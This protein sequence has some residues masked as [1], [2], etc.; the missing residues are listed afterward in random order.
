MNNTSQLKSFRPNPPD[1]A[2]VISWIHVGDLHMRAAGEQNDLDLQA[3][4]D[5]I[6]VTFAES[7]SFVF[8]PG[9]N[10][11]HGDAPA[12][13]VVRAA[14]DKL[15]VPWCAIVGDHDA[16]QKSLDNF[17]GFLAEQTHYAFTVGAV[18]FLALN[19][20]DVPEPSSFAVLPEQLGWLEEQLQDATAKEQTKVLLL[21]CYPSDLKRGGEELTRVISEYGVKLIEMGHTHYNEL[22]HDGRTIYAATRSTG[23]IEE[24]PVGFS[25]TNL[26][27]DVVSW[28]FFA[29]G[30]LPAV[31]ITSPADD[32]LMAD[33]AQL[34]SSRGAAVRVRA[35]IWAERD[36]SRVEATFAGSALVLERISGGK[37][38]EASL[39]AQGTASGLYRLR[40]V[41]T[42]T[43][44]KTAVDE[45]QVLLGS[46][47][48]A[49]KRAERDQDNALEAWPEHGLL[50]TQ[51]G[52]NKN[53]RKW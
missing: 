7:T 47:R 41:A 42:D 29:L 53:G 30:D 1:A 32:R 33:D 4:V 13:K 16:E 40:V 20:F 26:D 38:W 25:V 18:R 49:R 48:P 24:G 2:G 27:G 5:E 39:P 9:D 36:I 50:G 6:D 23:Q 28:R 8:L 14:L 31:I 12:Y 35:K 44:G 43:A 17:R 10:A 11:D 46:D 51:L 15:Q 45:I 21:H 3:I 22:S 19:A 52:P 37:V 34:D